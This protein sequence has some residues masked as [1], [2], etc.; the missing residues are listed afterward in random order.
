MKFCVDTRTQYMSANVTLPPQQHFLSA[1]YVHVDT[2]IVDAIL[3]KS[4][5]GS[6]RQWDKNDYHLAVTRLQ[7]SHTDGGFGLTPNVIAQTSA[8]VVMASRFLGLVGSLPL[9]EQHL[10]LQNQLV[11]DPDTWTTPHLLHLKR[12]YVTLVDKYG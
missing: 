12:E 9:D 11:H 5:R 4:T 7:M 3:R 1:Q 2:V 8:K 10:W 6:F